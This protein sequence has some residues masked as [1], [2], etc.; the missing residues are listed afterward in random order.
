[1]TSVIL[2]EFGTGQVLWS[3]LWLF[4]FVVWFWLLI[5][6]FGDLIRDQEM[7]G[8]GKAAWVFAVI[9]F[10]WIGILV[11]LIVRGK[12]MAERSAQ[13]Q[14]QAKADFDDYIRSQAGGSGPADQ[15]EKAKS[16]HDSGAISDEEYAALKAKAL[17]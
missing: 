11:Y 3:L 1:M 17:S 7:S 8:W 16:L 15:I 9:V 12:G 13:E 5:S 4:M 10:N 2:A 14:Q 6:I